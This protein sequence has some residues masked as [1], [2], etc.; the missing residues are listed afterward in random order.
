MTAAYLLRL[1]GLCL[2]VFFVLHLAAGS[3]VALLSPLAVRAAERMQPSRAARFL[4]QIRLIPTVFSLLVVI[5]IC[6]PSYLSL[7]PWGNVEEIGQPCLIAAALGLTVWAIAVLRVAR[8]AARS[9]QVLKAETTL[10]ADVGLLRP[11]LVV[12]RDLLAALP[13]DELVAAIRH[14][15][16]HGAS[17]DNLK[18]LFLLLT[19]GILPG[20]SGFVKLDRAWAKFTEWSADDRSV[21][22]DERRSVSL[23]SA[24]VRVARMGAPLNPSTLITSLLGDRRDLGDRIDRLLRGN[25][26]QEDQKPRSRIIVL[27]AGAIVIAAML[28]PGTLHSVHRLLETLTH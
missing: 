19:P 17:R 6:V 28:Q 23:A 16:A 24:L 5:G 2:A 3:L 9:R 12:S 4:L 8:A 25:V 15:E 27:V 22:G 26:Q 21:E 11:R 10:I 18:R 20:Y 1:L 7:E 14:E 13:P